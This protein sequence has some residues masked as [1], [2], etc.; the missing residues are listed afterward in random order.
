MTTRKADLRVRNGILVTPAGETPGGVAIQSGKIVAVGRDDTLPASEEEIDAKG[1]YILPGLIDPHL[2]FQDAYFK[3][4][5]LIESETRAAAAGGITT[6][7][8]MVFSRSNPEQSFHDILPS[9]IETGKKRSS[10][11]FAFSTILFNSDQ[12][13]ELPS[14]ATEYGVTSHKVM[15]AY[16]G[17][18]AEVFGVRAVDDAQILRTLEQVGKIGAPAVTM[19]HTENMDI[20][21]AYKA[22]LMATGRNDLAAYAE[23]RPAF[24]EEENLRRALYYAELTQAP[25]YV[26]HMSIGSGVDLVRQAKARGIKV[27]AETCP[28]FLIF[29]GEDAPHEWMGKVNPPIRTK[30][31]Q[32]RLWEGIASGVISTIGS[33]HSTL[34]PYENKMKDSLW[35]AVPGFP[36][37]GEILGVMLTAGVAQGRISMSR[38]VEVCSTNVAKAFGLYPRK[39]LLWPGSDG[40]VVIVDPNLKHTVSVENHHS[41]ATYNLYAGVEFQGWPVMSI[42]RGR[43]V[44][45]DNEIVAPLGHA[46]YLPRTVGAMSGDIATRVPVSA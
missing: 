32:D 39:G 1:N 19:I 2:H 46:E 18:E 12:I 11:D 9:Y 20:V 25:L 15:M 26:V 3:Y 43:V 38:L 42:V 17:P 4:E 10:V 29:T 16:R 37:T 31:H 45:K 13:E 40:D 22:K 44:M 23:A 8:P 7:I 6:V 34:M 30:W 14:Y 24:A 28:H 33:D 5:Q 36:G 35:S 41:A 27:T 21:Y